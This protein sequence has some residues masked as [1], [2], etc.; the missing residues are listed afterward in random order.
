MALD[1]D[2]DHDLKE[3]E[4][5]SSSIEQK[6]CDAIYAN[7][8]DELQMLLLEDADLNKL[9]TYG[10]K[11]NQK[12]TPLHIAC[13]KKN[14]KAVKSLLKFKAD[15]NVKAFPSGNTPLHIAAAWAQHKTVA[16]LLKNGAHPVTNNNKNKNP[17]QVI[18]SKIKQSKHN[19]ADVIEGKMET[20]ILLLEAGGKTADKFQ[21][22]IDQDI[23]DAEDGLAAL[24]DEANMRVKKIQKHKVMSRIFACLMHSHNIYRTLM[25]R[26]PI[27]MSKPIE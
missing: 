5:D 27:Y 17:L 13:S 11:G 12:I 3:K 21:D 16:V 15:P 9:G 20:Q 19:D 26:I 14:L 1:P 8:I 18:G 24:K 2:N 10:K 6:I 25:R 7:D 4:D 22:D 23:A